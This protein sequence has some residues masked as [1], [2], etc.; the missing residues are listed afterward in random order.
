MPIVPRSCLSF[1]YAQR[2][3]INMLDPY[4][5]VQQNI[6]P[7]SLFPI[8]GGSTRLAATAN[9]RPIMT[10]LSTASHPTHSVLFFSLHSLVP[11]LPPP[12]APCLTGRTVH[13][14]RNN[15][16][17]HDRTSHAARTYASRERKRG[18]ARAQGTAQGSVARAR[19]VAGAPHALLQMS[20]WH[21]TL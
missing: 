17:G 6:I 4:V 20:D 2:N 7:A 5:R 13:S 11:S 18:H 9:V 16:Q 21:L 12:D 3:H 19:E 1:I 8:T 14:R 15:V 10:Y